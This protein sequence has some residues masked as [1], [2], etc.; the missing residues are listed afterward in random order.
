MAIAPTNAER[1]AF[2]P[3][4]S[5]TSSAKIWVGVL[6]DACDKSGQQRSTLEKQR[7]ID[8]IPITNHFVQSGQAAR[9]E[10]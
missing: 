10:G 5:V 1:R 7:V 3:F 6:K 2:S 8:L 4:S 9:V